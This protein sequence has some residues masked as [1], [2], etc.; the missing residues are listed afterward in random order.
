MER[1]IWA[2]LPKFFGVAP[3]VARTNMLG[4]IVELFMVEDTQTFSL[5]AKDPPVDRRDIS[6]R[7]F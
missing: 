6:F 7:L 2:H 5:L 1:R 4:T 3:L